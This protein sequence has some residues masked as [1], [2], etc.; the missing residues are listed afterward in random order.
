[1][2]KFDVIVISVNNNNCGTIA[3]D[4]GRKNEVSRTHA[5]AAIAWARLNGYELKAEVRH[6][7]GDYEYWFN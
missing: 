4:F 3:Y 5:E 6:D 1:M 7:N 2:K